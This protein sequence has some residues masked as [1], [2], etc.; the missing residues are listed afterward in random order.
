MCHWENAE[1]RNLLEEAL[2]THGPKYD[3]VP[4]L[5]ERINNEPEGVTDSPQR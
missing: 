5:D 3:T 4:I 2:K 1:C